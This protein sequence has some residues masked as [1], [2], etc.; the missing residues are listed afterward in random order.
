MAARL[1]QELREKKERGPLAQSVAKSFNL[2]RSGDVLVVLR[3]YYIT[4]SDTVGAD[5]GQPYDYDQHVPVAFVP[6]ASVT[7]NVPAPLSL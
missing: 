3:K 5:H 1:F 7:G 2:Q 4:S 6:V